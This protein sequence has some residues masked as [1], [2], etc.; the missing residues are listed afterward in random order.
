METEIII[1]GFFW[2]NNQFM[3]PSHAVSFIGFIYLKENGK[4]FGELEEKEY[5]KSNIEGELI[6]RKKMNFTKNYLED[7]GGA[8]VPIAYSLKETSMGGWKGEYSFLESDNKTVQIGGASCLL[9]PVLPWV[10]KKE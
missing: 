3:Q 10:M 9:Y 7:K 5:G 1:M 8:Q 6:E 4:F 2:K